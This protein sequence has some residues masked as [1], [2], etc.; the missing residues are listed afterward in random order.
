MAKPKTLKTYLV[1]YHSPA[2]AMKKMQTAS[3]EEMAAGMAEWMKWANKCGDQLIDMG[4]PL[5]GGINLKAASDAAP[6]KRKVTGYSI[7]QAASM[8]GAK[9]LLKGH[10]HLVWS[11]GCEIEVHEAMPMKM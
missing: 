5:M 7:L 1:T 8:A 4:A 6:S 11:K 2:S 3:K 10:P 9:K